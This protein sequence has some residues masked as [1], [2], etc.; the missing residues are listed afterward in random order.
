MVKGIQIISLIV[1]KENLFYY[2]VSE[3]SPRNKPVLDS[4]IV[5]YPL[6]KC[7]ILIPRKT[8]MIKTLVK[9][10]ISTI[11]IDLPSH[12]METVVSLFD[13]LEYPS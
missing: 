8:S 2:I 1:V 4:I 7:Q 12:V 11:I 3:L 13:S 10:N 6:V 9:D 5:K